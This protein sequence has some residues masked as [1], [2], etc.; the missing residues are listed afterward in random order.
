M[1][2]SKVLWK[3]AHGF[4]LDIEVSL[5]INQSSSDWSFGVFQ[6]EASPNYQTVECI[7]TL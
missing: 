1:A 4:C 3:Q 2:K 5:E 6:M 7:L